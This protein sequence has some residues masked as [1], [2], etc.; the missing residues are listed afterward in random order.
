M[1]LL[2]RSSVILTRRSL[3]YRNSHRIPFFI[4]GNSD[5]DLAFLNCDLDGNGTISFLDLALFADQ[6]NQ[7][8]AQSPETAACDFDSDGFVS[9]SDLD[10][11]VS[12]LDREEQ[13]SGALKANVSSIPAEAATPISQRTTGIPGV[14]GY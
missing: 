12:N 2:C 4:P 9:L 8:P 3:S 5:L 11:L 13:V 1:S 14:G 10:I 6:V 7:V